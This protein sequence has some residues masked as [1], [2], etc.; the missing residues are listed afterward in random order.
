MSPRTGRPLKGVQP[1]TKSLQLRIMEKTAKELAECAEV[2]G[3]SRTEVIE[4]SVEEMHK[5]VVKNK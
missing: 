5:K 4:R 3:V 1:K 2:L